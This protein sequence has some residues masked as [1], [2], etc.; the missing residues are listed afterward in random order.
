[1]KTWIENLFTKQQEQAASNEQVSETR[2]STLKTENTT[3][4][5]R[6]MI[7]DEDRL[8]YIV[9]D[10]SNG[11]VSLRTISKAILYE[12][13]NFRSEYPYASAQEAHLAL[14]GKS[15][16][17]KYEYGYVATYYKMAQMILGSRRSESK[18]SS[19][20]SQ[21]DYSRYSINGRGKYGK[22]KAVLE[23]VKMYRDSHPNSSAEEVVRTW[24]G[25][26]INISNLVETEARHLSRRSRSNSNVFEKKSVP[27]RLKNGESIYV[28]NQI[29]LKMMRDFMEK[30]NRQNW[31]IVITK[32]D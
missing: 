7:V 30:V 32:V 28:S 16:Y 23:V 17:D 18:S 8:C 15:E 13:V 14:S 12:F 21:K 1:M 31:G 24:K 6:V 2:T 5:E 29:T 27:I 9:R 20:S 25:L 3:E 19:S 4:N 22:G 26:R 10:E 11:V